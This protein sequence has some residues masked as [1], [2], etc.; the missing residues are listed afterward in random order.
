MPADGATPNVPSGAQMGRPPKL[1]ETEEL[2]KQI[3]GLARIQCTQREAAAVLRVHRD[4][5]ADFLRSHEKAMEAWENGLENGKAS[6][7]RHQYKMAENNPTMA[8]WLGKQWLDQRDKAD[9][10]YSGPDGK[11][12]ETNARIEW[13]VVRPSH[14]EPAKD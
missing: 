3:E 13:V 5:F 2:L 11:P 4:T 10:Q 1:V 12:I 9:N 6:L 7:R 8:I 14:L